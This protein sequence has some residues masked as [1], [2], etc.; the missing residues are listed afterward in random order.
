MRDR[1]Y[2]K[3]GLVAHGRGDW[4]TGVAIDRSGGSFSSPVVANGVVSFGS[5]DYK[6]LHLMEPVAMGTTCGRCQSLGEVG[7]VCVRD[8]Q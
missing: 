2:R 7:I 8:E 6:L 5:N 3:A 4:P 1:R